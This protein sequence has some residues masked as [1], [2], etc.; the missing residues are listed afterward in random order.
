ML[1]T[2]TLSTALLLS[3][4]V[5]WFK[6]TKSG[7]SKLSIFRDGKL[8]LA[9]SHEQWMEECGLTPKM[10][11]FA[12][13]ELQQAG[14]IEVRV[15]KFGGA[16][17]NHYWL[18]TEALLQLI[19]FHFPDS[20]SDLK[21]QSNVTSGHYGVLPEGTMDSDLKAPSL[22]TETTAESTSTTTCTVGTPAP[23]EYGEEIFPQEGLEGCNVINLKPTK[24]LAPKLAGKTASEV[25]ANLKLSKSDTIATKGVPLKMLW[26]KEYAGVYGKCFEDVTQADAGK[27]GRISKAIGKEKAEAVIRFTV[28]DWQKFG[29]K[30]KGQK[31]LGGYPLRPAIGFLLQHYAVALEMMEPVPTL[32]S[33]APAFK[34]SSEGFGTGWN[35]G[36]TV[37]VP[38]Q[39][40]AKP[41]EE[42]DDDKPFFLSGEAL[43]KHLK[44]E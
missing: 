31:G 12:A 14:L 43:A 41:D 22:Y 25:V 11:R 15:W 35:A 44:G 23:Q 13:K 39:S 24:P 5:Y 27:L 33:G 32:A 40:I 3:Q 4:L 16:P 10:C 19:A 34:I 29:E 1:I 9:K 17:I 36:E 8:W 7:K 38:V 26:V 30:V 6:P 28:R 2:S 21:S 18:D 42:E 20:V 37:K